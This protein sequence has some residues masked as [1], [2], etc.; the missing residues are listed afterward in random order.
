MRGIER[1]MYM[2]NIEVN[3]KTAPTMLSTFTH[4]FFQ[5]YYDE[6]GSS[7]VLFCLTD[8]CSIPDAEGEASSSSAV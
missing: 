6:A 1:T 7:L 8:S 3:Y 4:S 2:A 5:E